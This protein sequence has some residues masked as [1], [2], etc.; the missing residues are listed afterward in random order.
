MV[1]VHY[2]LEVQLNMDDVCEQVLVKKSNIFHSQIKSFVDEIR[3]I[4]HKNDLDNVNEISRLKVIIPSVLLLIN[5]FESS[6]KLLDQN[7]DYYVESLT[8]LYLTLYS[9]GRAHES[10]YLEIGIAE[11][12]YELSKVRGFKFITNYFSS[13]VYLVPK[14]LTL[15]EDARLSENEV[16]LILIWLSNLVLVPFSL[17]LIDKDLSNRLLEFGIRN[18]EKHYNASKN[19]LASLILLSRLISRQDSIQDGMLDTY[20]NERI[21]YIWSFSLSSPSTSAT[22]LGHMMTINKLLKRCPLDAVA[23]NLEQIHKE[24]ITYDLISLRTQNETGDFQLNNLNV[25]YII[26]I[27][28]KLM[29]CYLQLPRPSKFLDVTNLVNNLIHDVMYVMINK[30]DTNL[31]YAMA[32]AFS[33]L[34]SELSVHAM[35]Y[36]EQLILYLIDQLD[37]TNIHIAY[38]P[39]ESQVNN[40]NKFQMD[41]KIDSDQVSIAK[42][43]TI[44]LFFAYIS[45]KKSLPIHLVLPILSIVHKTLFIQ[46]KRVT[47]VLGTQL[48][49]SSCFVLWSLCRMIKLNAFETLQDENNDMMEIIL[50]D[51]MKVAIFDGDL[52]IR[53]CSVAVIQEFI[54]RFGTSIFRYKFMNNTNSGEEMGLFIIKLIEIFNSQSI[55]SLDTSYAIIHDLIRLGFKPHLFIECLLQ[56]IQDDDVK[57]ELRKLSCHHLAIIFRTME[58]PIFIFDFQYLEKFQKYYTL[59]NVLSM[60]C[61]QVLSS[62]K[63]LYAISEIGTISSDITMP[64]VLLIV[65]MLEKN[66]KFDHHHDSSEKAEGYIKWINCCM[67]IEAPNLNFE[68]IWNELFN[69][70]KIQY[71][72]GISKEF[73][74]FFELLSKNQEII[75]HNRFEMIVHAIKS[76]NITIALN[77]LYFHNFSSNDKVELINLI[78]DK[79]IDCDTRSRMIE[80]LNEN[81]TELML[82]SS[83]HRQLLDMLDDYTITNQ[84]DVGS[85]VRLST[86]NLI[87]SNKYEFIHLIDEI[88]IKL[89][90]ISGELIDRLRLESIKLIYFMRYETYPEVDNDNNFNFLF[91]HYK[92]EVLLKMNESKTSHLLDLS[93]SFW[94]GIVFSLGS[95]TA[96]S[97]LINTA[98]IKLL[99]FIESL[100]HE[101]QNFIFN[102][103]LRMLRI[104]AGSS[105]ASINS[106]ELKIY[107]TTL[108]VFVK[109]FESNVPFPTDFDFLALFV[110]CYNLH[111]N[112]SNVLRVGMVLRIFQFL[113]VLKSHT[114]VSLKA[115]NRLCWLC[116]HHPLP[117]VRSFS[118]EMLFEI[119]NELSPNS[120]NISYLESID[121]EDSPSNLKGNYHRLQQALA[122]L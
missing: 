17:D 60:F 106:R 95:L 33:T 112:T 84:G 98:F 16:F 64:Y 47:S 36:Q 70:T 4:V 87:K 12:I 14:L 96:V 5:E 111:I 116:C 22:K 15:T 19:Q 89:L 117:Q 46:Q 39:Y 91:E 2:S 59:R 119:L 55:G 65:G 42:Y 110:R 66:F 75:T 50:F 79:S 1:T 40:K 121:W 107:I 72:S 23:N 29:K 73:K 74:V 109:L 38:S 51:I 69:I 101:D 92:K 44:L 61:D 68:I 113:A 9:A 11:I 27:T 100:K 49:D 120:E 13:D 86:I 77:V 80:C 56:N 78:S 103:L 45:F 90:R 108:H 37:I 26:K 53:R 54:G 62:G 97:S 122:N 82:H 24:V 63:S 58:E 28:S 67:I 34:S 31:R 18:L 85:K 6:P 41:L 7:L 102:E 83:M 94:K 104:P 105:L 81:I 115:R 25:L 71:S 10:R 52:T 88:E 21:K 114:D 8:D 3:K 30:F 20:F 32:K 57:F 48:R 76:N 93:S 118:C 35:N 99:E 43:H